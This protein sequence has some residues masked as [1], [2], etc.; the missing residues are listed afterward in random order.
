MLNIELEDTPHVYRISD[1]DQ[2]SLV[3]LKGYYRRSSRRRISCITSAPYGKTELLF[4]PDEL[5]AR[6]KMDVIV[7]GPASTKRWSKEFGKYRVTYGVT[8]FFPAKGSLSDEDDEPESHYVDNGPHM[9]SYTERLMAEA[10]D[11]ARGKY[12]PKPERPKRKAPAPSQ[13][14]AP[15][16][17][18]KASTPFSLHGLNIIGTE[19]DLDRMAQVLLNRKRDLAAVVVTRHMGFDHAFVDTEELAGELDDAAWLF[20]ITDKALE[21]RLS[22]QLQDEGAE[23]CEVYNGAIRVYPAPADYGGA[24]SED[25][26]LFKAFPET[27][28]KR[29]AEDI[30]S[31]VFG[32]RVKG[33]RNEP[34]PDDWKEA[35]ATVRGT[36]PGAN[37][38]LLSFAD[39][40]CAARSEEIVIGREASGLSID[41]F[42]KK[43]MVLHGRIDPQTKLLRDFA[44]ELRVAPEDAIKPYQEGQTILVRVMKVT[45][46][47]CTVALFPGAE[48]DIAAEYI[49]EPDLLLSDIVSEGQVLPAYI[50]SHE[51][52]TGEWLLSVSEADTHNIQP[53]PALLKGGPSWLLPEDLTQTPAASPTSS[54]SQE[55]VDMSG[56]IIPEGADEDSAARIKAYYIRWMKAEQECDA[57][58]QAAKKAESKADKLAKKVLSLKNRASSDASKRYRRPAL[59]KFSDEEE[60]IQY[61]GERLDWLMKDAWF[62]AFTPS[63]R[64]HDSLTSKSWHYDEGF[65]ESL[66]EVDVQLSKVLRCMIDV[67]LGRAAKRQEHPLRAN[68]GANAPARTTGSGLSVMRCYIEEGHASAARLHYAY[69]MDGSI[70]F[71]S[72]R[73]H[74][75]MRI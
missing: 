30:A 27:D 73:K 57:Q 13:Q 44:E 46:S 43:G 26:F 61:E 66:S 39:G 48:A 68:E 1:T 3:S 23:G 14:P 10:E 28:G 29:L 36:L 58:A 52:E 62:D 55:K 75:D 35:T 45:D 47:H 54:H 11:Y 32:L 20:E 9:A 16:Q 19:S 6:F 64:K 31:S 7:L 53:A 21:F 59:S 49:C 8:R 40:M 71:L 41:H 60:R 18:Q 74:D 25:R 12:E 69:E 50:V 24:L 17:K 5:C 51:K 65:F 70:L 22:A 63:D 4:D 15:A 37:R 33:W 42:L 72:V 38:A 34:A 2:D 67:L 56:L